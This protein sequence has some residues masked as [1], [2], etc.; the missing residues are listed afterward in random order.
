MSSILIL[1]FA[2]RTQEL[3]KFCVGKVHYKNPSLHFFDVPYFWRL[4]YELVANRT[5]DVVTRIKYSLVRQSHNK[6][7]V[8]HQKRTGFDGHKHL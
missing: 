1:V 8:V 4:L 2:G 6:K 5:V 7:V 3:I